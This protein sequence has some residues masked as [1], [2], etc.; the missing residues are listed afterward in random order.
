[1]AIVCV[2]G[3][4][5]YLLNS[6][7]E[8]PVLQYCN[9]CYSIS[10]MHRNVKACGLE[11]EH[12]LIDNNINSTD[13]TIIFSN[14]CVHGSYRVLHAI[15]PGYMGMSSVELQLSTCVRTRAYKCTVTLS[16][17]GVTPLYGIQLRKSSKICPIS[18][19]ECPVL[20]TCISVFGGL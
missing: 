1:M 17:R 9:S 13:L 16:H 7:S 19:N 11:I 5:C 2:R 6:C 10:I 18:I 8:V 20:H 4:T 15:V 12:P 3:V 14:R